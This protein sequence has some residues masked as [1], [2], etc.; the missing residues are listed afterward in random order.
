MQSR[1]GTAD[2]AAIT[3]VRLK[4]Q[5]G[6]LIGGKTDYDVNVVNV[7]EFRFGDGDSC[8]SSQAVFG[9]RIKTEYDHH[10]IQATATWSSAQCI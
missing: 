8:K 4:C 9:I 3:N 10:G 1:Q 6:E 7:E 2:D 5:D